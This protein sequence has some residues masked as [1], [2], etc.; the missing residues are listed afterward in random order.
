TVSVCLDYPPRVPCTRSARSEI[1]TAVDIEPWLSPGGTGNGLA[2]L[3]PDAQRPPGSRSDERHWKSGD[4]A[5][6]KHARRAPR[7]DLGTNPRH[8]HRRDKSFQPWHDSVGRAAAGESRRR[9][10]R[11][12]A[13]SRDRHL[14]FVRQRDQL[15]LNSLARLRQALTPDE[16]RELRR[17]VYAKFASRVS[18]N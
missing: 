5:G 15:V 18:L 16:Y 6:G 11:R 13:L 14:N 12:A 4:V 17:Q 9:P 7:R 3:L 8:D 1:S 2:R 10:D